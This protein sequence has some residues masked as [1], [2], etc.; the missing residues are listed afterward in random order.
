[1]SRM[2][3]ALSLAAC[4]LFSG[5][6]VLAV[7]E[8]EETPRLQLRGGAIDPTA[9]PAAGMARQVAAAGA[10]LLVVQFP[11]PIRD[12]W[13]AALTGA[14]FRVVSYL[15]DYAYLV[16]G[17]TAALGRLKTDAPVRWSG[18]FQPAWAVHPQVAA[19]SQSRWIEVNIQIV[20]QP[21]G[22]A[23]LA[24]ILKAAEA[25]IRRPW[26]VLTQRNLTVRIP[27]DQVTWVSGLPG[28]VNVEP[29]IPPVPMDEVQ[30]LIMAAVLNGDGTQPGAPGY[31]AWLRD[32]LHFS[33]D[34]AAYPIVDVTDDGI[35]DG[36]VTPRHPDFYLLGDTT[37]LDRLIYNYNWTHDAAANGVGGH[38]NLNA[39]IVV[40]YND[41][42][43]FPDQ[44]ANS[45]HHGLGINPFG[46][47]AGSKVFSNSGSWD[48]GTNT[49]IV[50]NSFALGARITN[51]SW[52]ANVSG[53]Y[54]IDSQ[55]YDAL[56]RDARPGT[57]ADAGN[58]EMITVFSA[59][60]AGPGAK[61]IGAPG[62]AKN[63]LTVGA[64]E[65][66]RPTWTDGCNM[67]A[68]DA[69]NAQEMAS[70]SSR[71][72]TED[73]RVKPDLVAPG[74]HIIGAASQDPG[75]NGTGVCDKY[76]PAGQ[77]LYAAS[78][79][80]SHSAPAV[81]GATSLFYRFYQDKNSG[82]PPSPALTKAWLVN[83]AR[84]LTGS[85]AGGT[86]PSNAQG[87]GV[88][89][90]K[91]AFAA[92]PRLWVDQTQVFN[93]SGQTYSLA[94]T[95]ADPSQPFRVTLAWTDA[96]GPTTGNSYVND[97]DL[98]VT[99][100]GVTYL[101]NVFSGG[102]SV[103]GG[104]A[105]P[106]N[107]VESVFLPAGVTGPFTVTVK[108]T[109]IAGDGLP[110]NPDA[111]DQDFALVIYNAKQC[112]APPADVQAAREGTNRILVK[113]SAVP[114]ATEYH[115]YRAVESGGPFK[116]VG[117][118]PAP[119][120]QY[121]D[122]VSGGLVYYY[123]V[124]AY[125]DCESIDSLTASAST[126][127]AC[128]EPPA[129]A[130]LVS[131]TNTEGSSCGVLLAWNPAKSY[132]GG[133]I[134]YQIHRSNTAP[135]DPDRSTMI[136]TGVAGTTFTD[137]QSLTSGVEV[138]YIVRAIDAGAST[139]E[140][141]TVTKSAIPTGPNPSSFLVDESFTS[142]DPPANWQVVNGGNTGNTG[143]TW[144]T[145]NPGGR[146]TP[147]GMTAPFEIIDSDKEGSSKSQDDSLLTPVFSVS[148]GKKI[149][150][151][152]DT[153]FKYYSGNVAYVDVTKDGGAT[154]T[155]LVTWT[156]SVGTD[157]AASHQVFDLSSVLSG[158]TSAQVRFHYT[159]T[160]GWYWLVDNVKIEES[161]H[162]AC[163]TTTPP[164]PKEASLTGNMTCR[165]GMGTAIAVAYAPAC[166]ATNHTAY[167]TKVPAGVASDHSWKNAA[168][169]LGVNGTA[170]FD[171]GPVLPG[172]FVYFVIVGQ[173]GTKEGSYGRT[174][175]GT[176]RTEGHNAGWSCNRNQDLSG[177]CP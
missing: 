4:L 36:S 111:T 13:Y 136:T 17:G 132:C 10:R 155:N 151:S 152:F 23:S 49:Q 98:T 43:G 125:Q 127:G 2:L 157:S 25:V 138:F 62:S 56:V 55:E 20:D 104:A 129:F 77:T 57:G 171:P 87:F 50:S 163:V 84:Y 69:D 146:G 96:P 24:A 173:T 67:T 139:G 41:K 170:T 154:W 14:G 74:T 21:E 176:E 48:A 71:G 92:T 53:S 166:G 73:Q 51:N 80:T 149:T 160:Y 63:V 123:T 135:F 112:I 134:Y 107:N 54:T 83:S 76:M 93:D 37:K 175:A 105:D 45:Y 113:W 150:L 6:T 161:A 52:G 75:Y 117:A 126:D 115:I 64:S 28:V 156:V 100:G 85:T 121:S 97:L 109:N 7:G 34:L 133:P 108:A 29:Y 99:V 78:S 19:L 174:S 137:L 79:G 30:G 162:L 3:T 90:L 116:Q 27:S 167:W 72:P 8:P 144:T 95:V 18:D 102:T 40:G 65:N 145:A 32:T 16:W 47:V 120:L 158:A 26:T 68:A 9:L 70:F 89:D 128:Q 42:T 5:M 88:L 172:E 118:V 12:E 58:Q 141:N 82:T 33:T 86:L 66:Y 131:A 61:T 35:D 46:R 165:R 164:N 101:G 11:G 130:G 148:S 31:L 177:V 122:S 94:A 22:E 159:G 39:S 15:P 60:N 44:D 142:G 81:A 114:G 140:L 38:G 106:R 59:G 124:R 1:M 169:F 110:G 147:G 103:T 153:Y 143:L 168:C 119:G 91:T